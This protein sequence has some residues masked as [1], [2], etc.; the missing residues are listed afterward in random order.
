MKNLLV[1]I[2]KF[3]N[4]AAALFIFVFA[5]L[6]VYPQS[7]IRQKEEMPSKQELEMM[8]KEMEEG[9]EDAGD[10]DEEF[11]EMMKKMGIQTPGM[12]DVKTG[13]LSAPLG[14]MQNAWEDEGRLIPEKD[15]A[16]IALANSKSLTQAGVAGYVRQVHKSVSE[17]AG[18]K[19]TSLAGEM[20]AVEKGAGGSG[21]QLANGLWIFGANIPSIL[22]LGQTLSENPD[23][24]DNLNNYAAFLVMTGAE[25][26]ALPILNFLN[27]KYPKNSTILNNIGQAWFGLGDIDKAT[28]YLDS[29]LA[30]YSGHSQA[31]FT[32]SEIQKH[33]GDKNGAVSSLKR[34]IKTAYSSAKEKGI[35]DMG[36]QVKSSDISWA[37]PISQDPLG[38][39]QMNWP[40]YPMKV[41]ESSTREK[42]WESYREELSKKEEVLYTLFEKAAEEFEKA[43]EERVKEMGQ[44]PSN[45][46]LPVKQMIFASKAKAGLEYYQENDDK[47][48]LEKYENQINNLDELQQ[49]LQVIESKYGKDLQALNDKMGKMIGEGSSESDMIAYCQSKNA[50]ADN[51]LKAANTLLQT[52]NAQWIDYWR[53]T[54][55]RRLNYFQYAMWPEEFEMEKLRA[56][57]MWLTLI[58]G[59]EVR[60]A[61]KCTVR[62]AENQQKPASGKLADFYDMNC[63]QKSVMS[64]GIGSV[65]IECNKMTTELDAG[66]LK[67]SQRENMD[68]G[69]IIRG[70]VEIGKDFGIGKGLAAGPVKAELKAGAG[71]FIEFDSEGITDAGVKGGIGVEVGSNIVSEATQKETGIG[72]QGTTAFGAEARWGWNSGGSVAG[73]GLLNGL[74]IK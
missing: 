71:A 8:M 2:M 53:K 70:T 49:K 27:Q 24:D 61:N 28:T 73:K 69:T 63:K 6:S 47:L 18:Q 67:Y 54:M 38:F 66:F 64:L 32:K 33:K 3:K 60:F 48:E 31:N 74:N 68:N 34:S 7:N 21:A 46:K 20:L 22:V 65:T 50:I 43:L 35:T 40:A 11:Q 16:R 15:A 25:E 10:M 56:Q 52:E 41:D 36:H 51:Y 57:M 30:L 58:G 62:G 45:L 42:E 13:A 17:K 39:G 44:I 4:T 1:A 59:Q 37:T 5:A 19:Q 12:K 14:Q 23:N 72:D 26:A 9:M 55:S 29:A